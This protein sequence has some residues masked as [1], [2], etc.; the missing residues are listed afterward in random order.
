MFLV[1][2]EGTGKPG[3]RTWLRRPAVAGGMER[4]GA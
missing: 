1:D 4:K 2:G 3:G